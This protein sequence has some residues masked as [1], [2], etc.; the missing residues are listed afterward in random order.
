MS[1]DM[2]GVEV[3]TRVKLRNG[4]VLKIVKYRCDLVSLP[5]PFKITLSDGSFRSYSESGKHLFSQEYEYDIIEILPSEETKTADTPPLL[6][7]VPSA[8]IPIAQ[9]TLRDMYFCAALAGLYACPNIAD[10]DDV[11]VRAAFEIA[12]EALK[13]RDSE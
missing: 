9:A 12:D 1:V 13:Q 10:K 7:E 2:S 3:G 11:I 8:V 5:F 4:S 6:R